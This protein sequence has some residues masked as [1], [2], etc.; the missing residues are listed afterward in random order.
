MEVIAALLCIAVLNVFIIDVSG[1]KDTILQV[2]TALLH[3]PVNGF[4][5]FTCS[6]CMTFWTG[7]AY[8]L[9]TGSL[10]LPYLAALSFVAALTKPL[11]SAFIF[12]LEALQALFDTLMDKLS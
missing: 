6:L 8:L 7:L 9:I 1:F 4:R 11:A 5:P 3:K 2:F 12:I 10:S